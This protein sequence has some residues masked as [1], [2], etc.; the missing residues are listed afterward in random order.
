MEGVEAEGGSALVIGL[1]GVA[2]VKCIPG[3]AVESIESEIKKG[4]IGLAGT[5]V[6]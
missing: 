1:E 2:A 5:G 4:L 6:G 3:R